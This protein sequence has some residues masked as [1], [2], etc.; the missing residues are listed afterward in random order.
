[1]TDVVIV[2]FTFVVVVVVVAVAVAVGVV[3]IVVVV[4]V[5]IIVIFTSFDLLPSQHSRRVSESQLRKFGVFKYLI[6]ERR[7]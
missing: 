7:Q 5:A 3:V 1:M 2:V 6:S 4:V